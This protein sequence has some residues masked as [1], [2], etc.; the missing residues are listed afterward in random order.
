MLLTVFPA[1]TPEVSTETGTHDSLVA[2]FPSS[3]TEFSPQQ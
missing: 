3:P 1:S 2:P